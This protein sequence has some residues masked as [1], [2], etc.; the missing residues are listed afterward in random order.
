M[1]H[2]DKIR[3]S[4]QEVHEFLVNARTIILVSN[5]KDG[6]P[7]PMPMWYAVDDDNTVH[8]TTFGKSQKVN[9]LSRD[10]RATLLVESG[11]QYQ[12]LRGVLLYCQAEIIEDIDTTIDTLFK[13]S[14]ARGDLKEEQKD[15]VRDALAKRAEKR[16]TLRFTPQKIV[17]WDHAKLATSH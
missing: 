10:S 2:R 3:M 11:N 12:E 15:A 14:V 8:M 5:G 4:D 6:Y 9:N 1:S 16:V 17:S 13:I 7:H